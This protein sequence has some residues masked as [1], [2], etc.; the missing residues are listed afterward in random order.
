MCDHKGGPVLQH[1][2]QRQLDHLLCLGVHGGGGLVQH[3]DRGIHRQR[4]GKGQKL[5]LTGGEASSAL[6]HV[7]I[8]AVFQPGDHILR[9]DPPDRIVYGLHGNVGVSEAE[10]VKDSAGEQVRCLQ[11]I[12]DVA[13]QP[14][15]APL[16]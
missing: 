16:P 13:V 10:I 7:G 3:E 6:S 5:P 9:V 4:P 8:I 14:V 11:D 1:L 12:A 2:R 15:L